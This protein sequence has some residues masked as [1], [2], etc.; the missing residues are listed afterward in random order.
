MSCDV[1]FYHTI[2][3][4]SNG[5]NH[6]NPQLSCRNSIVCAMPPSRTKIWIHALFGTKNH[7]PLIRDGFESH[8]HAH[9]RHHL[10]HDFK[11][12]LQA[13]NGVSDHLHALILLDPNH[14]VKDILKNV[15]GE[16]SHWI[17]EN[18]FIESKFAW[19]KGYAA[20]SVSDSMVSDV[21]RH[22]QQQKEYHVSVS[23]SEECRQFFTL[24]RL[25]FRTLT[26]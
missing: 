15:K 13:I 17:N 16:S 19:E 1:D 4:H 14:S 12:Y 24:H 18:D 2:H 8:L 21:E 25:Q 10:E 26:F 23:Y 22:I 9:I 5:L 20:V 7:E 6:L 3:I 11:C